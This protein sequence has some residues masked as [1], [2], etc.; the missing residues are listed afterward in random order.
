MVYAGYGVEAGPED[1][2]L[3]YGPIAGC[4]VLGGLL[5]W[6]AVKNAQ[7]HDELRTK[8]QMLAE[9]IQEH[10]AYAAAAHASLQQ[11]IS[12]VGAYLQP[13]V[14]SAPMPSTLPPV[15]LYPSLP[16]VPRTSAMSRLTSGYAS[17]L[18]AQIQAA[19]TQVLSQHSS[20]PAAMTLRSP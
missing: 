12:S 17:T 9:A 5:A 11:Q 10:E 14:S 7:A 3:T 15:P 8:D 16:S 6:F 19:V 4:L 1:D 2:L 18:P 20:Q 13:P